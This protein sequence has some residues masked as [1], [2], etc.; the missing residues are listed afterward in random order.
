M[1]EKRRIMRAHGFT[2]SLGLMAMSCV[3]CMVASKATRCRAQ[4]WHNL[5]YYT[6]VRPSTVPSACQITGITIHWP[7]ET[8]HVHGPAM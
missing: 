1:R 6:A 8:Y 7:R 4:R 3:A 5:M 2:V